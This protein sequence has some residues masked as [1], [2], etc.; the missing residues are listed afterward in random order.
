M[1]FKKMALCVLM[2]LVNTSMSAK[3]KEKEPHENCGYRLYFTN[4]TWYTASKICEKKGEMLV[5]PD[6]EFQ[7]YEYIFSHL[8]DELLGATLNVEISNL[9][10]WV[11]AFLRTHSNESMDYRCKSLYMYPRS[12]QDQSQPRDDIL[13]M[14]YHYSTGKFKTDSCDNKKSFLCKKQTNG[15]TPDC[16]MTSNRNVINNSGNYVLCQRNENEKG[17]TIPYFA[18]YEN[19]TYFTKH[20]FQPRENCEN[21]QKPYIESPVLRHVS[22]YFSLFFREN[23]TKLP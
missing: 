20:S 5:L 14:F 10:I 22:K 8:I 18:I 7:L 16:M 21:N 12:I 17:Q 19:D 9:G 2:L 13:C 23:L 6:S 1:Y 4:V 15:K 11:G 3:F